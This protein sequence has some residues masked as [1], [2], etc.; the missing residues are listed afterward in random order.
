MLEQLYQTRWIYWNKDC[1][2]SCCFW[3]F[4]MINTCELRAFSYFVF[5]S[6]ELFEL[7]LVRYTSHVVSASSTAPRLVDSTLQDLADWLYPLPLTCWPVAKGQ[8]TLQ[9]QGRHRVCHIVPIAVYFAT[10]RQPGA[11]IFHGKK[12]RRQKRKTLIFKNYPLSF[13]AD[14]ECVK[15]HETLCFFCDENFKDAV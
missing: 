2:A 5:S 7:I 14:L 1:S 13:F 3:R 15:K 10:S 8:Q 4:P 12:E 6:F 9:D 11:R